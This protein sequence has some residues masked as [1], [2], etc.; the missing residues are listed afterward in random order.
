MKTQSKVGCR[1]DESS[2]CAVLKTANPSSQPHDTSLSVPCDL[3]QGFLDPGF[4]TIP[5]SRSTWTKWWGLLAAFALLTHFGNG[6][7]AFQSTAVRGP[8][9]SSRSISRFTEENRE[10]KPTP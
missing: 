7:G 1:S 2:S 3:S 4:P 5:A 8:S 10:Q 9:P 6:Q